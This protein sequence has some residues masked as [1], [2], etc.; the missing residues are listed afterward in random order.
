MFFSAIRIPYTYCIFIIS[1][2]GL[3]VTDHF[4]KFR[5]FAFGGVPG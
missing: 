5:V 4:P 1:F 2:L 3:G